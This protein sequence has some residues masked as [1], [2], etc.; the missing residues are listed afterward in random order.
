M[1]E[2][3][4]LQKRKRSNNENVEYYKSLMRFSFKLVHYF[5]A[6]WKE[7]LGEF[8]INQTEFIILG[9]VVDNPRLLQQEI[10]NIVG[11][12]KSIVSRNIKRL[13]KKKLVTRTPNLEYNHAYFCEATPL[14]EQIYE[15]VHE[16]GDPIIDETFSVVNRQEVEQARDTLMKIWGHIYEK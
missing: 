7:I 5:N 2:D 8:D 13:E 3:K 9:V 1:L 11:T 16:K 15:K 4:E 12:D 10:V 14:G 6:Y